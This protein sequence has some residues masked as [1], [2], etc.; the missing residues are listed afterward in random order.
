MSASEYARL[1]PKSAG[2]RIFFQIKGCLASIFRYNS[3]VDTTRYVSR[4]SSP[5][6]ARF[7][8]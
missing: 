5:A 3:P 7:L 8:A 1:A 4:I 2:T 6:P